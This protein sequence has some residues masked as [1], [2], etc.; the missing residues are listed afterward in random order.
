MEQI[1]NQEAANASDQSESEKE[2]ISAIS[3]PD[4]PDIA[5]ELKDRVAEA[6]DSTTDSL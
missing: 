1:D 2:P 5:N 6:P 4:Q 3:S